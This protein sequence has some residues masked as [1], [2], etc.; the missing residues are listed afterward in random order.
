MTSTPD[1]DLVRVVLFTGGRGSS[2]LSGEL[3]KNDRVS[4][5]LAI[6]GYDDGLSTGE[7]RRF[8]GD[9]LGPSDFRKNASRLA[10]VLR[11]CDER[12]VQLL[13]FRLPDGASA[14]TA[15]AVFRVLRGETAPSEPTQ[16][17]VDQLAGGLKPGVRRRVGVLLAGFEAELIRSG[18][19]FSFADCSLGNL[20][21]A[22]CFLEA[23]R[24]FNRAVTVYAGLLGLPDGV[25]E[26]VT[27]GRN[28]HLVAVDGQGR[29]I[30][31]EAAIVTA[32]APQDILDIHLLD[33][34]VTDAEAAGLEGK[35][36][37]AVAA[38]LAPRLASPAPNPRLLQRIAEADLIV[39]APGT[40][41]SSLFPSY[42]TP[43]LGSAIAQNL[44]AVKVLITNLQED[45]EISGKSAVDLINKALYYLTG[46]GADPIP[47]PCLITHYLINEPGAVEPGKPYVPLGHLDSL[48]DPRLV[49]IGNYEDGVTG[50]HDAAKALAPF[51]ERLLRRGE[52]TRLA[53]ILHDSGSLNK[54]GETI[55]EMVRAGIEAQPLVLS[56]FYECRDSFDA[57]FV[58]SLPFAVRNLTT[59]GGDSQAAFRQIVNDPGFDFVL[60]FES[61]G[62]YRGDDVVNLASHLH[63]GRL[64]AVWGSRRLSVNDIR[65]A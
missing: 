25:I 46:K 1:N 39:Y 42:L 61:S 52:R 20:V 56:V 54:V 3:V 43:G 4:L 19:P 6:N 44:H 63:T 51:V 11:T 55:V 62:M 50:R 28:L 7:V 47:T 12:L 24:D 5:T 64:D 27:D 57:T 37:E 22:G 15:S 38:F 21:F 58:E 31:N 33:R 14:Q 65:Q 8:L 53:V 40:Q 26:N 2:V 34:P 59:R 10:T 17:R 9:C 36:P 60:L 35:G 49:R 41:H 13:D 16:Q 45:A 18:Y 48:E 32:A 23:A 30:P 29:L